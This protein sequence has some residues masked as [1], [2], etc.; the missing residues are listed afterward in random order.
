M[1]YAAFSVSFGEQP[2]AAKWNILGT[3]DSSFNDGTGSPLSGAATANVAASETT[4]STNYTTAGFTALAVTVT[5]PND[6]KLLIGYGASQTFNNTSAAFTWLTPVV[7]GAN[8]LAAS[9]A[10]AAHWQSSSSNLE[11]GVSRTILLTS[12]TAGST[13]ITVNYKVQT[14]GG[15]AGTGTWINRNLWAVPF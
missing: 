10:Y 5:V 12:Q 7:S 9:D 4:T 6:G 3:N 15:G 1:A 13:T 8:T 2:S 11:S 14:G